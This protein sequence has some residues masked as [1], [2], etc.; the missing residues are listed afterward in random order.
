MDQYALK[1]FLSVAQ[2]LHFGR[3]GQERNLSPSAVSRTI[4]RLEEE[5]GKSLF[6]RDNRGVEL[7]AAGGEFR[8]FAME[9]L[10]RW[11]RLKSA[12][13]AEDGQL[14]GEIRLYSSVTASSTVLTGIFAAFRERYPNV[15]IRLQTGD[16]AE[17]IDRVKTQ[18]FDITVAALPGSL[19]KDLSFKPVTVTPLLFIAPTLPCETR[20]LVERLPIPWSQ[21]PMVLSETGLS[22]R[23]ADAW[24]RASRIKPRVYA[25]VSGHE[26]IVSMV[27]LGCG[28]GIVPQLAL[29]RLDSD[30]A[31]RVLAVTPSLE[32]YVVGLCVRTRRLEA[33]AVKA[34]WD[35]ASALKGGEFVDRS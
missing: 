17:A 20:N 32:P 25:E 23:R 14:Q 30:T 18:E 2:L 12:S 15:H 11:E 27:R 5:L 7:T 28:V 24:F 4:A 8:L 19:P 34:F 31:L 13:R 16:P 33:P 10:E 3:A 35:I 26:A 1:T 6:T 21:I 22:R 29:S 9:T